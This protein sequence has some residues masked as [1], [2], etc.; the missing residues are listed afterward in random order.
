AASTT[1]RPIARMS[2][3]QCDVE[4]VRR[5]K[6]YISC[7]IRL[8]LG[9]RNEFWNPPA[10]PMALR[11]AGYR[12]GIDV[13]AVAEVAATGGQPAANPPGTLRRLD[14]R[15]QRCGSSTR[16]PLAEARRIARCI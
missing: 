14:N 13:S 7:M 15:H 1:T 4:A 12:R 11:A 9:V 6:R 3:G 5:T 16:S 10:A 8:Q 2:C